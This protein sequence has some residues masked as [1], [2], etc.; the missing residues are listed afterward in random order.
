VLPS[1]EPFAQSSTIER[2]PD[3][4]EKFV[5]R[6]ITVASGDAEQSFGNS[7]SGPNLDIVDLS[8]YIYAVVMLRLE[9]AGLPGI[10]QRAELVRAFNRFYTREIGVLHEHLL[11]SDFSLTEVR[12]L[13]E[14]AR[15][16]EVTAADLARDLNL[17]A[18]YLSRI[19]AGFKARGFLTKKRSDSD[20]RAVE[21][22]LSK[23]GR[24]AFEPLND[25]SQREITAML[26]KRSVVEQQQVVDAMLEIQSLL[27]EKSP[28]YLLRDPRAGDMGWIVHRHGVLYALE[29][30]WDWTFE[31]LV[32]EI[33]A[34]FV[35]DF[36]RAFE[37]C[38]IAEQ[39]GRVVGSV[40]VVRHGD[41]T[42]K[43]RLLYV[44]PSARGLGIG[45]RLV[46]ECVRFAKSAGY[47]KLILWTNGVLAEARRIYER[48]GFSLVREEPHRSFGKDLVG[49]TWELTL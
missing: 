45:R 1:V 24:R 6:E 23:K 13:Y 35:R 17:D 5:S 29:Y 19:I 15:R 30:G 21:L 32:A 40:F 8:K 11:Q 41:A 33:V 48:A 28:A 25:A 49:Q 47:H 7:G 2:A 43:L 12:V 37:R 9:A 31:A 38:W 39:N 10:A 46:D 36:D 26:S 22:S 20:A 34:A 44:E 4:A 14:L 3:G 16:P 18:G 27:V 42:A